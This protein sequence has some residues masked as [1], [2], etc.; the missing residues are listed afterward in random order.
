MK[1]NGGDRISAIVQLE[2]L[3]GV[4]E[5]VG[6]ALTKAYNPKLGSVNLGTFNKE[7]QR[8]DLTLA[9][10]G[11]KF[12]AAGPEGTKAF[13]SL[14]N[15]V[16]STNVQ[17]K[18]S[19][20]LL[21]KMADTLANTVKW[22]IASKA[23]NTLTG[24]VEKAYYYV[25]D[26]DS[27][28]NDIRIVTGK[29]AADM[30]EFAVQ[31]NKAAKSLGTTTVAYS[32]AA[33]TFFQQGLGDEQAAARASLA[34][35]V[36]NVTGLNAQDSAQYVTAVLNGYKVGSDQAESAMD[37]LANV[38][39]H[40][41]SSLAELSQAMAKVASAANTMGV[42]EDQL[43]AS[44]ATV[45]S[46]TRQQA[47]SVGTAFKTIYARISDIEAGTEDAET[48][49]GNY[50]QEMANLG[51]NVLDSS[52]HLRNL[53]QVMEEIGGSW[54]RLTR[55]QQVS[56]AQTMAGTRQYNQLIALF[57]NWDEYLKAVNYSLESNGTLQQQQ[58][59]Y[60]ESTQAHLKK[61]AAAWED[62][63]DSLLKPEDINPIIDGLSWIVKL[64]AQWID[65]IG[66]AGTVIQGLAGIVEI[67]FSRK[68]SSSLNTTINNF[69]VAKQNAMQFAQI[70]RELQ[71]MISGNATADAATQKLLQLKQQFASLSEY[72]SPELFTQLNKQ[73][74]EFTNRL[75]VVTT[76]QQDRDAADDF[77]NKINELSLKVK[78][79][80]IG[81]SLDEIVFGG[82]KDEK[83]NFIKKDTDLN[84]DV[85]AAQI[86]GEIEEVVKKVKDSKTLGQLRSIFGLQE[87][88]NTRKDFPLLSLLDIDPNEMR[89]SVAVNGKGARKGTGRGLLA[90]NSKQT[91]IDAE[92]RILLQRIEQ[93]QKSFTKI[94]NNIMKQA[95]AG[96]RTMTQNL[97]YAA[98]DTAKYADM[99]VDELMKIQRQQVIDGIVKLNGALTSLSYVWNGFLNLGSIWSNQ[100]LSFGEKLGQTISAIV[101]MVPMA[102]MGIQNLKTAWAQLTHQV[103]ENTLKKSVNDAITGQSTKAQQQQAAATRES[104]EANTQDT[105]T[106]VERTAAEAGSIPVTNAAT[107][108]QKK[109]ADATENASEAAGKSVGFIAKLATGFKA[110]GSSSKVAGAG[111]SGASGVL[112]K[113][114]PVIGVAVA[115]IQVI[116]GIVTLVQKI[117]EKH[118]ETIKKNNQLLIEQAE[119]ARQAADTH[120]QLYDQYQE[121]LKVYQESGQNREDLVKT[122][123][124]LR[125]AYGDEI[126]TLDLL[127]GRYDTLNE[128]IAEEQ[129]LAYSSSAQ[130]LIAARNNLSYFG[131]KGGIANIN[132]GIGYTMDIDSEALP[133]YQ[134]IMARY[135][136]SAND[137]QTFV[138][139]QQMGDFIKGARQAINKIQQQL[140]DTYQGS[141]IYKNLQKWLSDNE[142]YI[143]AYETAVSAF[144]SMDTT[145][146]VQSMAS[147]L[148]RNNFQNFRDALRNNLVEVL[149]KDNNITSIYSDEQ[150]FN[151]YIDDLLNNYLFTIPQFSRDLQL[152][153]AGITGDVANF[154]KGLSE[155]DFQL[156]IKIAT[157]SDSV[158]DLQKKLEDLRATLQTDLD[159]NPL[160]LGIQTSAKGDFLSSQDLQKIKKVLT[161]EEYNQVLAMQGSPY[162]M[163]QT[164]YGFMFKKNKYNPKAQSQFQNRYEASRSGLAALLDENGNLKA[165]SD[166][167][168][169]ASSYKEDNT[170]R[171][172]IEGILLNHILDYVESTSL[173]PDFLALAGN[174]SS[175]TDDQNQ[176]DQNQVELFNLIEQIYPGYIQT[177]AQ[178]LQDEYKPPSRRQNIKKS[179]NKMINNRQEQGTWKPGSATLFNN[180]SNASNQRN[181]AQAQRD[182][183]QQVI[184]Q[185]QKNPNQGYQSMANSLQTMA[186]SVL[187]SYSF[188]QSAGSLIGS[189]YIVKQ[190]NVQQLASM[191]PE[192]FESG[193]YTTLDN[194]DVQ[195]SKNLVE[196]LYGSAQKQLEDATKDTITYIDDLLSKLSEDNEDGKW[197]GMIGL[198][199]SFRAQLQAVGASGGSVMQSLAKGLGGLDEAEQKQIDNLQDEIDK[200]R[201]INAKID[202]LNSE[203][204]RLQ[205]I[206][207]HLAGKDLINNLNEQLSILQ[208]QKSAQKQKNAIAQ[209]QLVNLQKVLSA[210]GI[211]F[212]SLGQITNAT[213]I[214]NQA[215]EELNNKINYY[216]T[217]PHEMTEQVQ[218]DIER[219]RGAYNTLND[220]ISDYEEHLNV[221][222]QAQDE[223]LN[224]AYEQ[225]SIQI[226]E[227][228]LK[229]QL[230]LDMSQAQKEWLD[231]KQKVI[232]EIADDDYLG[233]VLGLRESFL[234]YYEHRNTNGS[235]LGSGGAIQAATAHVNEIL[236]ELATMDAG[237]H[238]NVYS[239]YDDST[240]QWVD[241]RAA[242]LEDLKNGYE[243]LM[244][245]LEQ[246]HDLQEQVDEAY[247]S[248]IDKTKQAY[249]KQ[250]ETYQFFGDQIE[251]DMQMIQLL[252]GEDSYGKLAEYY[253]KQIE[254]DQAQI[255]LLQ[256]QVGFW[257]DAMDAAREAGDSQAYEKYQQNWLDTVQN[258][259]STIETWA[260]NLANQ[261]ENTISDILD[262]LNDAITNGAGL[263]YVSQEF[264]LLKENADN[265]LDAVNSAYAV[266]QLRQKWTDAIN[267][268]DN[269][270][271]QSELNDLMQQQMKYLEEKGRLTQYDVDRAEKQYEIALKQIALQQAQQNKSK[272]RLRRDANGNY[273]YQFV[274]D[275]DAINQAQKQLAAAQNELYNFD[276]QAYQSN[277]DDIYSTW[278]DF[279]SKIQQAYVKYAN[280]APR[281]SQ[282]V[283]MLQEQYAQRMNALLEQNLGIRQNLTASSFSELERLYGIDAQTFESMQNELMSSLTSSWNSGVQ[284]MADTF[285]GQGGFANACKDSFESLKEAAQE[286]RLKQEQVAQTTDDIQDLIESEKQTLKDQSDALV[287]AAQNELSAVQD[288]REQVQRLIETYKQASEAAQ[289]A[290]EDAVNYW[291]KEQQIMDSVQNAV[292]NG[293]GANNSSGGSTGGANNGGNSDYY[294]E[295]PNN[296]LLNRQQMLNLWAYLNQAYNGKLSDSEWATENYKMAI[297]LKELSRRLDINE[298][299]NKKD[300]LT[301]FKKQMLNSGKSL[302][303]DFDFGKWLNRAFSTPVFAKGGLA[304]YTGPAWLDGTKS[305]PEMVLNP[306]DTKNML[307]AMNV[308]DHITS[309]LNEN[310]LNIVSDRLGGLAGTYNVDKDAT[311]LEQNV[312]IEAKFE[313]QTEAIQIQNALDNLINVAAQRAYRTNK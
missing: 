215:Y 178:E 1:R 61:L 12:E 186:Q 199:Q 58:N 242:A 232:D 240:G 105:K 84:Y 207:Q 14:A 200:Y 6:A 31:A 72:V 29:S 11:R 229:L 168:S 189:D 154:L 143:T 298:R 190:A 48:T 265:Y 56:L 53:G 309:I 126:N 92:K 62:V 192:L 276:K 235:L 256:I 233:Q 213:T 161:D 17:L 203:L 293:P 102:I 100:D 201:D 308:L 63:F 184:D 260:N 167:S 82:T 3:K 228:N 266:E 251:H 210:Y 50:T 284:Q 40:T 269:V 288:V 75:N 238:S 194:G 37:K 313:G 255:K 18:Q 26:L 231:F 27:S 65:G 219:Q 42:S 125:Q 127:A 120:K 216:N 211:V 140:P 285:I 306:S 292:E 275:E 261:Y 159:N 177:I 36:Q 24:S 187:S 185:Y 110:L 85:I 78:K 214:L 30:A 148:D 175:F 209:V 160:V 181:N 2:Q 241:D 299:Y 9:Q 179:I 224:I 188:Y 291:L 21:D 81:F 158:V 116:V 83:G 301:Y 95:K 68:I 164:L 60:M 4:A 8:S 282:Q 19:H 87:G 133:I 287:D 230:H 74:T 263:D 135:G 191:F 222:Q 76:L 97:E 245:Q 28:L 96:S 128:K 45:I 51:F 146:I 171:Y 134:E 54:K 278:A 217:H 173:P 155:Q 141:E 142:E 43:V 70:M 46:A 244:Q 304:N 38:G 20:Q 25:K 79:Q 10:I 296:D 295:Y 195:L 226:Q 131:A 52:G 286:Y 49:L 257:Q 225:I 41:A 15:S 218:A 262:Q 248:S 193:T 274:S 236:A 86:T 101:S 234:A 7:L 311:P 119:K 98:Q 150:S 139:A 227:F 259:N 237:R 55:Q 180:L 152:Q 246:L 132:T 303:P 290:I 169:I 80:G 89:Q 122:V 277:L 254:S 113:A 305:A 170:I 88:W 33:L 310:M 176:D 22:Q 249:D 198:L 66:G 264:E 267:E 39:A 253:D 23:V 220:L 16:T 270:A 307:A 223:L 138:K 221:A 93:F 137:T 112:S 283:A 162:A 300:F 163:L 182:V 123:Q 47:S 91:N 202:R 77:I 99:I 297:I 103:D 250:M 5:D 272:M 196:K 114:I 32:N 212:S 90:G 108:A 71:V 172:A 144:E 136:I 289:Q 279:Q 312:Y 258:L 165:E 67:A 107:E 34:T 183:F 121:Q 153:Q 124:K 111:M 73:F 208:K 204:G 118:N 64:V 174:L 302:P 44:L 166:F 252:Y 197:T 271:L 294:C 106:T 117:Q 57:D 130:G 281:L 239:A 280:D 35:K 149:S 268:Q 247:L 129:R 145:G 104:A 13:R 109:Q 243:T 94:N 206:Q 151:K 273:T 157:D 147:G 59:V 156:L 115:A 69:A 205:T